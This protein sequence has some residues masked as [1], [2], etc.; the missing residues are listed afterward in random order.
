MWMK[1]VTALCFLNLF[2]C[3]QVL[4]Q[5]APERIDFT[6]YS[7]ELPEINFVGVIYPNQRFLLSFATSGIVSDVLVVEGDFVNQGDVL[8]VLDQ[9]IEALEIERLKALVEDKRLLD[10]TRRRLNLQ[11]QQVQSVRGLYESTGS[12]SLDELN[13]LRMGL[14]ALEGEIATLEVEHIRAQFDLEIAKARL[15]QRNL[16][17]PDAGYITQIL[18]KKGEWA[19][20]GE[21]VVE[22]VDTSTNYSRMQVDDQKAAHI[23]LDQAVKFTVEGKPFEGTISYISPVADPASG[24]VEVKVSFENPD[25]RLRPGLKADVKL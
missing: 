4:A 25:N 9:S 2:F 23:A 19:Q 20:F 3:S 14:S 24:L 13:S 16:K 5:E 7:L 1:S 10:S 17:A 6:G 21:P 12:V 18:P 11:R 15:E 22:L 8:V